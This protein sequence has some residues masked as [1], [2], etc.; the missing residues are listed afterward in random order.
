MAFFC[1]APL[2]AWMEY[3]HCVA[4]PMPEGKSFNRGYPKAICPCVY[5]RMERKKEPVLMHG[6]LIHGI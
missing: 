1:A 5:L 4:A 2:P 3:A 6:L